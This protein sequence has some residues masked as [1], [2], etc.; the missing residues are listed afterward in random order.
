MCESCAAF[1][2]TIYGAH[3]RKPWANRL[4]KALCFVSENPGAKGQIGVIPCGTNAFLV[5][6]QIAASFFGFRSGNSFNRDLNQHGFDVDKNCNII[7]ELRL[8]FLQAIPMA[9]CWK[10]RVFKGGNFNPQSTQDEIA[11]ASELGRIARKTIRDAMHMNCPVNP[12][13]IPQVDNTPPDWNE[14][15]DEWMIDED[16]F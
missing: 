10:K 15:T 5:N 13:P 9:R 1:Q 16:L 14:F 4:H 11:I 7:E 6:S 8:H 12:P 3:C 2:Q